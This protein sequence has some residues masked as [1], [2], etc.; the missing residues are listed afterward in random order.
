[1]IIRTFSPSLLFISE[2]RI[3]G[4][5]ARRIKDLVGFH[6]SV[7]VDSAGRSGGLMLLWSKDWEVEL[8]S[9]TSGHIDSFVKAPEGDWWR[10]I[11]FYGHPEKAQRHF[12]WELLRRL[13]GLY[14]L[15]WLVAGDDE[16]LRQYVAVPRGS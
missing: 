9:F 12:S 10:F 4:R 11:G 16:I 6:G 14:T 5:A 7:H 8:K 15:P 13:Q 3:F 2:T 1:M